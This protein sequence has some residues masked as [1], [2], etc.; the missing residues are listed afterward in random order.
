LEPNFIKGGAVSQLR[1]HH[2]R[3]YRVNI[4]GNNHLS[5]I[6]ANSE[7]IDN[8]L[9][10]ATPRTRGLT[11]RSVGRRASVNRTA[12]LEEMETKTVAF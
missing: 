1:H 6:I 3:F 2:S 10:V 7:I 5:G 4:E 8:F 9:I 12:F 11:P